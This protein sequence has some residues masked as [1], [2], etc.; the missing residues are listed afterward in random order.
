M[1]EYKYTGKSTNYTVQ[2]GAPYAGK[3]QTVS[4]KS[5]GYVLANFTGL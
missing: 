1:W 3:Q 5:N 4:I 2:L